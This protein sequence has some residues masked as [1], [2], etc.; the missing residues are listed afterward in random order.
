MPVTRSAMKKLRQDKKRQKINLT[1]KNL[2]KEAIKKMRKNPS[3]KMLSEA[4]R[5]LDFAKKKKIFHA[6]KSA[7]LKSRLSKLVAAKRKS[8]KKATSS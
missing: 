7:R 5:L 2:V 6:K 8:T 3:E 4:F 1:S